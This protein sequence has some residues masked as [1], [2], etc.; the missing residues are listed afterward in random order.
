MLSI[1][2]IFISILVSVVMTL[3]LVPVTRLT[4][5]HNRFRFGSVKKDGQ[6]ESQLKYLSGVSFAPIVL[7]SICVTILFTMRVFGWRTGEPLFDQLVKFMALA[8]GMM[9]LF[10]VGLKD[11]LHGIRNSGRIIALFVAALLI[12]ASGTWINNFYG[13]FGLHIV[14]FWIGMPFTTL[15]VMYLI[16]TINM[17]DG[18]DGL[19]S[20]YCSVSLLIVLLFS[21][22]THSTVAALIASAGLGVMLTFFVIRVRKKSIPD[23]FMGSS[24]SLPMGYLVCFV[25]LHLYKMKEWHGAPDGVALAAFC[26]MLLPAADM[27]RVIK[28]RIVDGRS[29]FEPDK[30][31]LF[32]KLQRTGL[33]AFTSLLVLGGITVLFTGINGI[34]LN[35]QT[36]INV[37]FAADVTVFIL[38]QLVINY[39]I[40]RNSRLHASRTWEKTYGRENWDEEETEQANQPQDLQTAAKNILLDEESPRLKMAETTPAMAQIPF[41]PDGMNALERNVKRLLDFAIS[42]ACLLVFSPLFLFSYIVIKMDDGGPAIYKQQRIGRFGRPF[43]I[44]KFRSMRMDAEKAGP[45]LSHTGGDNDSRLTK[46]GLFLRAHHLD[47][48]PQLWN[49][50][51][52]EMAFI[53]YRPERQFFIEQIAQYDPRY[54]ML[55]QI[56]PGVTS[57]A[58]LY[59]GYTDTMEKM[60]K[61]LELD[62]YYLKHRSWW[63]DLKILFLTFWHIVGGKKF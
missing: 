8:G 33:R 36:S 31:M 29:V 56:R 7:T 51:C 40:R 49:V 34:L 22:M 38:A 55:Y 41:I 5:F 45:Q 60:L 44:Y 23:S 2:N 6:T 63:F 1:T 25:I 18:I 32:H 50:F 42:G 15:L 17:T 27:L 12:S 57:Y 3:A 46:A 48:L 35:L 58:T 11:D 61:R 39:I 37:L 43:Y 47:E 21:Y 4:R 54:Y 10:L 24:G 53:G 13:L 19:A 28:S 16:A 52:G 62:L 20:G 26:T 9:M 14:P 59:N 30:N